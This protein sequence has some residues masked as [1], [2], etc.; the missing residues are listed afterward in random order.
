MTSPDPDDDFQLLPL[1]PSAVVVRPPVEHRDEV[2]LVVRPHVAVI[3]ADTRRAWGK[4]LAHVAG[5]EPKLLTVRV[6]SRSMPGDPVDE[7]DRERVLEY[8]RREI[9]HHAA[10]AGCGVLAIG[11]LLEHELSDGFLPTWVRRALVVPL[12]DGWD[13]TGFGGH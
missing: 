12:V 10:K 13:G 11:S 1:H 5:A 4:I 8:S 7:A 6:P 2:F 3:Q 9:F